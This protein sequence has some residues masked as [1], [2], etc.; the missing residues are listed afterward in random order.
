MK[1]RKDT[2][3]NFKSIDQ[4]DEKKSSKEISANHKTGHLK[5]YE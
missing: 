3:N 4:T 2:T 5:Y 1:I